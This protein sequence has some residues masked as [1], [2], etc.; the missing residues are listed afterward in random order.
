MSRKIG[1]DEAVIALR[2][3]YGLDVESPFT[4]A[5]NGKEFVFDC[6]V[7]GYGSRNGMIIDR[8][9]SRIRPV[10][11]Q[12]VG[13]GYGYSCFDLRDGVE[14]MNAALDDWGKT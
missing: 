5:V 3:Q 4:L 6:L 9:H 11:Y 13:M 10:A 14:N 1:L 12:L 8:Y 2:K 7:R